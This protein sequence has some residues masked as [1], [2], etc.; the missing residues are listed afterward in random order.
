MRQPQW[1]H[2]KYATSSLNPLIPKWAVWCHEVIGDIC[3]KY[4]KK[5]KKEK[6]RS[7]IIF[8]PQNFTKRHPWVIMHSSSRQLTNIDNDMFSICIKYTMNVF[9][10]PICYLYND[11]NHFCCDYVHLYHK[12][13]VVS[14]ST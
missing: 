10:L 13:M 12:R 8:S 1:F 4:L 2:L 3:M 9:S 14:R 11:T 7:K 5:N 6:E